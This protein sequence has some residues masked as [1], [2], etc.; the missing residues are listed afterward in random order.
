MYDGASMSW[1]LLVAISVVTLSISVILRRVMLYNDKSDPIAYAIV[2]QSI[3]GLITGTYAGINGFDM[4]DF[5]KYGI[6]IV[7]TCVLYALGN[8]FAAKALQ[9]VEASAFSVLYASSV[10]WTIVFGSWLL[11][12]GLTVVHGLGVLLV[13]VGISIL[14][15]VKSNLKLGPGVIWGLISAG[16]FGVAVIG[17]TYVARHADVPTWTALSFII[18]ALMI[19]AIKPKS[20]TQM[21][22]FL[23]KKMLMTLLVLGVVYGTA[24]LTSLFAYRDGN[25]N[26]VVALQQVSIILTT[27]L[28]IIFLHERDNIARK[29]Y[30]ALVCVIGV[31]L[32]LM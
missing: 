20:V 1:Q 10:I 27:I 16:L 29:V 21:K 30:S 8:V 25:V 19:L 2:F 4:P 22:P 13:L 9:L 26:L 7:A 18:P 31:I 11:G 23:G 5:S 3:V 12:D 15:P 28:G 24:A 6:V 32:I 17:W 14:Y